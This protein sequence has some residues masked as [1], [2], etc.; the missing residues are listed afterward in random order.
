MNAMQTQMLPSLDGA[1]ELMRELSP[2]GLELNV[3]CLRRIVQV[4]FQA[5]SA[6]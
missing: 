3:E 6:R 1:A 2:R 5:P 4:L